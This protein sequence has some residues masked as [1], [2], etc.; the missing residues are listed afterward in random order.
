VIVIEDDTN[1]ST[2]KVEAEK[3]DTKDVN[4]SNDIKEEISS[5]KIIPINKVWLGYI[6]L[7]TYKKYQK[8]FIDEFSLDPSKD[9]LLVFGHGNITIEVN[10]II[11]KFAN[12]KGIR[13]SYI[14]GELKEITLKE[15]KSLNRGNRW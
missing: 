3:L 1:S 5:F 8:T 2:L 14:N 13:F 7:S 4:D 15:F 12:K 10:G 11:K 6:D 9:W